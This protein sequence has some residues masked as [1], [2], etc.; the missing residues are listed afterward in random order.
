MEKEYEKGG[1][2]ETTQRTKNQKIIC[3]DLCNTFQDRGKG[4]YEE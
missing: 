4:T 2:G 1:F 3:H